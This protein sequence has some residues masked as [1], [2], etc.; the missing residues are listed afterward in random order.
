MIGL[1]YICK[2]HN[3]PFNKVAGELGLSR[4][5]V[6][7]W[8]KSLNPISKKHLPKLAQMFNLPEEY[9]QKKLTKKEEIEISLITLNNGILEY[10]QKNNV[11]L[12]YKDGHFVEIKL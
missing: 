6:H 12:K 9:F 11:K 10:E 5:A 4:Q 3:R 7:G 2:L 1:E 8:L